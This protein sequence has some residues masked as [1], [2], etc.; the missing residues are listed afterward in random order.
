M[1]W[2]YRHSPASSRSESTGAEPGGNH[3]FVLQQAVGQG[4]RL[5]GG[6]GDFEPVL[7]G[8]AGTG[9]QAGDPRQVQR[10]HGHE[11]H[12]RRLRI[13]LPQHPRRLRPLQGEQR[14]VVVRRQRAP[15]RAGF[16][17]V[18]EIVL[19]AA[20]VDHQEQPLVA[21]V[22]DH[23]VV[24][25]AAGLVGEQRVALAAGL[26]AGDVARHQ[27]LHHCGGG[28]AGQRGLAHVRH[29]EQ[30]RLVAAVQVFGQHAA[31]AALPSA[32]R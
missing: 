15:R 14:A 21:E 10:R 25:D 8:V 4:F 17:D 7:A 26:Q 31:A 23:Q 28:G 19:L 3:G 18:G 9:D 30:R 6:D 1:S 20:G 5:V 29:V 13:D 32:P 11:A 12:L 2:P 27:P 16:G 24:Q 22:G